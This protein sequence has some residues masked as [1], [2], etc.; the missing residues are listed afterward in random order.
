MDY[1][2]IIAGGGMA[3]S[4]LAK[5]LSDDGMKVLVL[6][7]ET[8]FRDRIRGEV[9]LRWGVAE[10]QKL[11]IRQLLEG[12]CALN[13]VKAI[14]YVN[15]QITTV[16]DLLS[17]PPG[18][19]PEIHFHH[20]EMQDVFIEAAQKS[21]ADVRRGVQVTG[22]QPGKPPSVSFVENGKTQSLQARLVVAADGKTSNIR[23]WAGFELRADPDRMIAAGALYKGIELDRD[24]VYLLRNSSRGLVALLV[25]LPA[26]RTR[27]YVGYYDHGKRHGLS[28]DDKH[29]L[30]QQYSIETG[31]PPEWFENAESISILAEFQMASRW[32]DHPYQDGVVLLGDAASSPDPVYGEGMSLVLR[33][34]RILRKKLAAHNDWDEAG[35]A[36][37]AEQNRAFMKLRELETFLTDWLFETGEEADGRRARVQPRLSQIDPNALNL[38]GYGPEVPF[39]ENVREYLF[40]PVPDEK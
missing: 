13:T 12:N 19:I 27:C 6:E 21:G 3:G 22:V 37:A 24:A 9:L 5:V 31:C 2:V 4:G 39:D 34:I 8:K 20:P 14:N 23:H 35:H 16:D 15:G 28:G 1:D 11:G 36:Y 10:A 38:S 7:H 26:E 30:F 32:V 18:K 33:D 40:A 17:T 25:P 29:G